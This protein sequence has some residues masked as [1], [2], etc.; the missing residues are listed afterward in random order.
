MSCLRQSHKWHLRKR[1]AE[2]A[3]YVCSICDS[4]L[5]VDHPRGTSGT[6]LSEV[7]LRAGGVLVLGLSLTTWYL[8]GFLAAVVAGAVAWFGIVP[9]IHGWCLLR[10]QK[11]LINHL[12]DNA[13]KLGID[14]TW[15]N[16]PECN[17]CGRRTPTER[18]SVN[19]C[20]RCHPDGEAAAYMEEILGDGEH[21]D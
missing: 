16:L 10:Y 17:N 7:L 12:A 8:F 21:R 11:G 6:G 20:F 5:N 13:D 19:Y 1:F 2:H 18:H 14:L 4:G 3:L 15:H 9:W